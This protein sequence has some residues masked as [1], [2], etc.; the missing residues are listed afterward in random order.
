MTDHKSNLKRVS[1]S[2]APLIVSF[3]DE[4]LGQEFHG[5]ELLKY[6]SDRVPV[7]PDSP[8]RILR[9][10]RR[11]NTINYKVESRSQSRYRALPIRGRLF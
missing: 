8:G 9:E 10:L 11:K 1:E 3:I 4:R 5:E 7:A 2:I 6:V